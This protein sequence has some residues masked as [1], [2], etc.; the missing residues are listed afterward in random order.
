MPV[1]DG[2]SLSNTLR[3][4]SSTGR[5]TVI[6][7]PYD[8]TPFIIDDAGSI[9]DL[10]VPVEEGTHPLSSQYVISLMPA[11]PAGLD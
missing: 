7:E 4:G 5:I 6:P 3:S 1:I 8:G 10:H 9:V 2:H 11:M